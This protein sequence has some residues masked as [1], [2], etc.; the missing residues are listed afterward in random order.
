VSRRQTAGGR[1]AA[2]VLRL[3]LLIQTSLLAVTAAEADERLRV[4][5]ERSF[6]RVESALNAILAKRETIAAQAATTL[7]EAAPAHERQAL[8]DLLRP[9]ST[10]VRSQPEALRDILALSIE[11]LRAAYGI[12][13]PSTG[14]PEMVARQGG[15]IRDYRIQVDR[16][17]ADLRAVYLRKGGLEAGSIYSFAYYFPRDPLVAAWTAQDPQGASGFGRWIEPLERFEMD[18]GVAGCDMALLPPTS[19]A[20]PSASAGITQITAPVMWTLPP[21]GGPRLELLLC[22]NARGTASLRNRSGLPL[23]ALTV[24]SAGD[25]SELVVS[26]TG[27]PDQRWPVPNAARIPI[28]LAVLPNSCV[29]TV[30]E[31][32]LG[33]APAAPAE[34]PGAVA[35]ILLDGPALRTEFLRLR[36]LAA[37]P[38]TPRPQPGEAWNF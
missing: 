3:L 31:Y 32:I 6:A 21:G 29:V 2:P 38:V 11:R 30:G 35:E 16:A 17:R 24:R 14:W 8:A 10:M 25:A 20:L 28:D 15:E 26:L 18:H 23:V 4:V 13:R 9:N 5:A 1:A 19:G 27:V 33:S 7:I 12:I 37:P 22:G 34:G 36:Y